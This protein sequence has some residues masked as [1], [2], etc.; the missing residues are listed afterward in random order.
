VRE[1]VLVPIL[2]LVAFLAS[3]GWVYAD[4]RAHAKSGKP[5]VFSRGSL[6]VDTPAAWLALCL[7]LWI[8]AFPVYLVSRDH[9]V[10]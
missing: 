10:R 2:V 4:A 9:S 7:I 5:V 3:D 8:V 6:I 1:V